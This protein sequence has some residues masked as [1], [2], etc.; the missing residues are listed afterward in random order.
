MIVAIARELGAGGLAVGE[1]VANELGIPL[2]DKEIVDL[3]AQ[4]IGAP[5]SY[6]AQRDE[7]VETFTERVLRGITAAYPEA[8]AARALP[9]W[10]EQNLVKLTETIIRERAAG[11][12]LVVIGRGAPVLLKDRPDV[13]RVF[14]TAPAAQRTTSVAARLGLSN[15]DALKEIR[16]SDQHRAAYYKQHYGVLDWR[17]PR[18][19]DLV[20]NTARFGI[21]GAARMIVDAAREVV[22]R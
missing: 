19:Y 4:R 5:E 17:D 10:S 11:E 12:S 21:E 18:H 1:A 2:L 14:L 22:R 7:Q 13:V 20:V 9:D 16:R 15:E 8:M 6:V 3:V